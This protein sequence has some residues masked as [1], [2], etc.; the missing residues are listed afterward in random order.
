[1]VHRPF[2]LRTVTWAVVTGVQGAGVDR[3]GL[4]ETVAAE[5]SA[6]TGV[7]AGSAWIS[8]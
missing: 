7:K 8:L 5:R 2:D 3:L 4:A 1:M 6:Q